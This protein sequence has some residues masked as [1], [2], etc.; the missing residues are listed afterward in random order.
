M[1]AAL[2][3][4]EPDRVPYNLRPSPE[5]VARLREEQ[6][7]P[8]AGSSSHFGHDVRYVTL[9]MSSRPDDVP[10]PEWV[11]RPSPQAIAGCQAQ[12]RLLQS[13]GLAVSSSSVCKGSPIYLSTCPRIGLET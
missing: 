2:G 12:T 7:D 9:S 5:M 6:S 13:R 10:R 3:H 8:H 11:P 1:L 4:R